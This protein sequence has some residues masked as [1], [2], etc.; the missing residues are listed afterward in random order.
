MKVTMVA[1]AVRV[2]GGWRRAEEPE[3]FMTEAEG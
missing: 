2:G 1:M 3:K